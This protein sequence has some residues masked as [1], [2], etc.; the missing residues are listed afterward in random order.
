MRA[1]VRSLIVLFILSFSVGAFA[2]VKK[3]ESSDCD[4]LKNLKFKNGTDTIVIKAVYSGLDELLGNE[5]IFNT[6]RKEGKAKKNSFNSQVTFKPINCEQEYI[7]PDA[8]NA[9]SALKLSNIGKQL[10]FTCVVFDR[11]DWYYK[12]TPF[13][14]IIKVHTEK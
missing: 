6:L 10:Y 1:E 7:V 12:D 8:S 14:M 9:I 13:F 5:P 2:Q 4:L 11:K 3:A